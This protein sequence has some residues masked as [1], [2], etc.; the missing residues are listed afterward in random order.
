M[1]R[2]DGLARRV[3]GGGVVAGGNTLRAL[4][5]GASDGLVSNTALVM[6]FAGANRDGDV[7]ILA[8][9]AGLLS[10]GLSMAAGEYVSVRAQR[11]LIEHELQREASKH[12][13]EPDAE[14]RELAQILVARGLSRSDAESIARVMMASPELALDTHAREEL[15]LDP[16]D[17]ASPYRTAPTSFVAFSLGALVPIVPFLIRPEVEPAVVAGSAG[18]AAAAMFGIGAAL[19][20]VTGQPALR[21]GS[22]QLLIG[23]TAA[24]ATFGLGRL[25]DVALDL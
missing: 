4:I 20:R 21:S 19:T 12:Q 15:G 3:A 5:F 8:G 13:E 11:E 23:G 24:A 22:R 1:G 7:V 14:R 16:T 9:L 10:G 17:L 25:L 6:G 2:I 18:L